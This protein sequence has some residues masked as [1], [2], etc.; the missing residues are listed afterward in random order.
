MGRLEIIWFCILVILGII[1]SATM[2]RFLNIVYYFAFRAD[3][4]FT[5]YTYKYTGV[6]K[7]LNTPYMKRRYEKG[8]IKDPVA[9]LMDVWAN[10]KTGMSSFFVSALIGGGHGIFLLG[11]H[12]WLEIYTY[13]PDKLDL[14]VIIS[15]FVIAFVF[16]FM[17]V[18]HKDK[19][20][21][22]F[23][24]FDKK[25]RAWKVKWKW[26]SIGVILFPFVFFFMS[27]LL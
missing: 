10:P 4:K 19:Y 3:A 14:Y 17:L 22:Y 18:W 20:L 7:L 2:E 21:K 26:I 25:P 6:F 5:Y 23:K 16:N 9:H 15:Y 11:I 12:I 13:L 24:E 8:G 1:R 27:M